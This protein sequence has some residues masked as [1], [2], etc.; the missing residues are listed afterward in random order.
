LVLVSLLSACLDWKDK[1]KHE[2]ASIEAGDGGGDSKPVGGMD[3]GDSKPAGDGGSNADSDSGSPS[4]DAG[5]GDGSPAPDGMTECPAGYKAEGGECV[6]IDECGVEQG[7]CAH[8]CIDEP[9]TFHC[10]CHP[11]FRLSADGKTCAALAWSTPVR[12]ERLIE[13]ASMAQVAPL[14]RGAIAVWAQNKNIWSS[15]LDEGGAWADPVQVTDIAGKMQLDSR[16]MFVRSDAQGNTM[17]VW[18]VEETLS[19]GGTGHYENWFRRRSSAGVWQPPA[20]V[21]NTHTPLVDLDMNS[22][23]TLGVLLP[24]TNGTTPE[25][26]F[27]RYTPSSGFGPA[28]TL[29]TP[30][31]GNA[32][33]GGAK[34]KVREDGSAVVV[35]S[36]STRGLYAR[37]STADGIDWGSP[38]ELVKLTEQQS[39][40]ARLALDTDAT[41]L[42]TWLQNV[43]ANAPAPTLR[44][45]RLQTG[46]GWSTPV[47]LGTVAAYDLDFAAGAGANPVVIWRDSER[48]EPVQSRHLL[49]GSWTPSTFVSADT[50][51]TSTNV[52]FPPEQ[53]VV[54]SARVSIAVWGERTDPTDNN[55]KMLLWSNI[56]LPDGWKQRAAVTPVGGDPFFVYELDLTATA[57]GATAVWTQ[58]GGDSNDIW[59]S[60]LR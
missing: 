23:G 13:P 31:T 7:G 12:L 40:L 17:V 48:I 47:D 14:G 33:S 2:D 50:T 28:R 26:W 5:A 25:L 57:D 34:V 46:S 16:K 45:S 59:A 18:S 37:V 21:S 32:W 1:T 54:N 20:R 49:N 42:V 38:S 44:A 56:L 51:T 24:A 15:V 27:A 36:D 39:L 60:R 29:V 55:S 53:R 22:Q 30:W 41:A 19:T 11:G 3:A 9:G 52:N 58:Y 8:V 10:E 35:W 4:T 6:N 43:P